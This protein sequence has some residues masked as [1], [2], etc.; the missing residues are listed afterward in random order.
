MNLPI[1]LDIAIG[2]FFI[3]LI[4]SLLASELQELISTLL[5]WRAKHLKESITNL[6]SGGQGTEEA[7][8]LTEFVENLYEDPLIKNINQGAGG[9]IGRC[10]RWL[11]YN[12]LYRKRV[13]GNRATGPSYIA[14]ETFSTTLL[15]QLGIPLLLEKLTEVRLK[16]F[17]TR[18]I[19][20]YTVEDGSVLIPEQDYFG[21]KDNW[22]KGS[23]RVIAERARV[24]G[25]DENN[26]PSDN[27][28]FNLSQDS[29][30]HALIE[31]YDDILN[32]Y[33]VK[34]ATLAIAIQRLQEG[35]DTY[36]RQVSIQP[37]DNQGDAI[38]D[39]QASMS[40]LEHRRLVFFRK[41]LEALLLSTFGK[42]NER[43][44]LSG[45]LKPTLQE[46][47]Q[48][49][50]RS[51]SVYLEISSAYRDVAAAYEAGRS[52]ETL[53]PLVDQVT[54]KIQSIASVNSPR[55]QSSESTD[56]IS[57]TNAF[58]EASSWEQGDREAGDREPVASAENLLV[59]FEN[60][61]NDHLHQ[62]LDQLNP[63]EREAFLGWQTYHQII[64]H[65]TRQ[66]AQNL[67]QRGRLFH[68]KQEVR[69]AVETLDLPRLFNSVDES[70]GY[71]SNEERQLAIN[72]A[73]KDLSSHDR[74]F[75][76]NYQTYG[77]LQRILQKVPASVKQSLAVLARRAQSKVHQVDNQADQLTQEVAAWFDRS[78]S[79]ASGVYKRN[80]KG[81]AILIGF[82]IAILANAD[83]FHIVSRLA[84]DD[85]LRQIIAQRAGE[86]SQRSPNTQLTTAQELRDLKSEVDT[87][88]KEVSFPIQWTPTNLRDQ[89][90]C[91]A[92]KPTT[93]LNDW[94]A[95]YQDCLPG[96]P[97]A[98]Q[99]FNLLRIGQMA[100]RHPINVGR[101]LIGWFVSGI[102]IS[103]GAP[104]WFDLLSK[105]MNVRNTGAK[106]AP[107][108]DKEPRTPT[109]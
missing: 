105:V 59:R 99:N 12:V 76:Q 54:K 104:F 81:V 94:Q 96:Q 22:E 75:F 95:F 16:K 52:P 71:A 93:N 60:Q 38:P 42:E 86:I 30:F 77:E 56:V 85:D 18:L 58:Q 39:M 70:L 20:Q 78:M 31:D 57:E 15:E 97:V 47:A 72:L 101:M 63:T 91:P 32:D 33:Q 11:Y 83:T 26:P 44:V 69:Q 107:V 13:F 51:S 35:L 67:Q 74:R 24:L 64:V 102:A 103:M 14:P 88:L 17:V 90:Y 49:F 41:R 19:G 80:A 89:L 29:T 1:I 9:M 27:P 7:N 3:Y 84:D 28:I 36:I 2:L 4:A 21:S 62:V 92:T 106:P 34:E 5:Q 100:V 50:D 45:K 43:A 73:L 109:V 6:L 37:L 55:F 66:I 48:I 65:V 87:V 46:I 68:Q 98:S 79:R 23:V 10:G 8:K 53:Q 25:A 40:K 82:L 108:V 61:N